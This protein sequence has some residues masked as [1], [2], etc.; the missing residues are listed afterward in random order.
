MQAAEQEVVP[1]AVPPQA[2]NGASV[3]SS[4]AHYGNRFKN[5]PSQVL[6]ELGVQPISASGAQGYRI[7]SASTA[8]GFAQVGLQPGDVVLSVNGQAVGNVQSD[9]QQIDSIR[10]QGSAKLEV[11]RGN[12]RFFITAALQ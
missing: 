7:G 8:S 3:G 1:N 6:N 11:Q 12:R 9:R 4:V 10:A 5:D 2:R